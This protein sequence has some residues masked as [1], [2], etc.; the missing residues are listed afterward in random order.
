MQYECDRPKLSHTFLGIGATQSVLFGC[1][2]FVSGVLGLLTFI[3]LSQLLPD[4]LVLILPEVHFL[5]FLGILGGTEKWVLL[6]SFHGTVVFCLLSSWNAC[7]FHLK[8]GNRI[9]SLLHGIKIMHSEVW[10][11]LYVYMPLTVLMVKS[12]F[13]VSVGKQV[14]INPKIK[15]QIG[16]ISLAI[17][18]ILN[19][20]FRHFPS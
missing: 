13:T 8:E 14:L 7:I 15:S 3:G 16:L 6:L 1:D 5:R 11:F 18:P 4:H 17:S 2:T 12:T 10:P 9:T 20:S 19:W